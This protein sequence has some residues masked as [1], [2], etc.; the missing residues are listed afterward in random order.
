MAPSELDCDTPINLEDLFDR[1]LGNIALVERVIAKFEAGF[2][3]DLE[4]LESAVL[5]QDCQTAASVAHRLK[6]ASANISARRIR[7]T[8]ADVERLSREGCLSE[9]PEAVESLRVE[10][11]RFSE[12]V[13][14]L[15]SDL[16][17]LAATRRCLG[18]GSA[19]T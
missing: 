13:A 16:P 15:S 14:S 9:V 7:E 11:S 18:R 6:G 10:R 19:G 3:R 1:C 12:A 5:N 4:E 2:H 8:A 17:N